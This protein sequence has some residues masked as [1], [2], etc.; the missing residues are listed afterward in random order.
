MEQLY[1]ESILLISCYTPSNECIET[2]NWQA[3]KITYRKKY[4]STMCV[5]VCVL[6]TPKS[7]VNTVQESMQNK[8]KFSIEIEVR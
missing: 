4:D 2:Y 7:S 8:D 3:F 6:G 1:S 5:C